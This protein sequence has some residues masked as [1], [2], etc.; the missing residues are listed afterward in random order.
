M[1]LSKPPLVPFL[2]SKDYGKRNLTLNFLDTS[3]A[4]SGHIPSLL[5]V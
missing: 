1:Q 3:K 4:L 2:M 5:Q